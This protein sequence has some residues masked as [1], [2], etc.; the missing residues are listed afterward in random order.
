MK[1]IHVG[2]LG[3]G[4][5]GGGTWTVLS[6]NQEEITR[7]A[8][9]GIVITKVADKDVERAKKITG[10]K[11]KVTADAN[12][13]VT[14]PDIDIVIELIGGY[15]F[16]KDMVLKAIANGKHVVT[17]NKALLAT[18]GNEIFAAAQKK[19]VMVAFEA[20][21]AGGVPIIK[22]LR[23][24]LSAN[25]IEWIAGI[26][27]GTS[28]FILSEMRDKGL[29]FDTVLAQAQKLGYAEADPTF[30]IE[31][32]DAAHKLTIM[33][34]IAF[35]IPMQ[36][37][38]AYTEGITKLTQEDIRYAEQLGYRIKL[39][40]ITRKTAEG[41]ELRVHPTL[42]PTRRLIANVEGVMNA[43]LVKGDAVGATMYYGAGA[44]AEPTASAV[45]ADLVDV[46]RMHTADPEQRVPHLAFQPDQLAA[47]VILPMEE[48]VTSYYL[49]M[50]VLDRPGVLADITR[51][52]AD[53]AI[54]IDAMVQKEPSEG[55]EQ[56]DIIM[57]THQ[58]REKHV[59]AAIA[60]I[61]KL[62]VVTGKVTRIRLEELGKS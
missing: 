1:P 45:V 30:D 50:R 6:R 42:I 59:N 5:V 35:G 15:T 55:E 62:P 9:R 18:H 7:R 27:N 60:A 43:I 12:E 31:G 36:F 16:A 21:V 49:R 41:I 33:S 46:T 44:G 38:K 28:N 25:R 29:S 24:G 22:A 10:G 4:T 37:E 20:A 48:V 11:A 17:A 58:A 57:L 54:S 40:G 47:T 8:G 23:E 51:I 61:E 2:L 19:G 32:I 56:V 13:V 39:L 53:G 26:I 34:A 14:D 3:I 52:L